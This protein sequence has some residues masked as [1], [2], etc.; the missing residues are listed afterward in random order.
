MKKTRLWIT[1]LALAL[2]AWPLAGSR[3]D[4]RCYP[5]PRFVVLSGGL[6]RDTLTNL[7]WQQQA[8][9]TTVTWANAKTYC[10]SSGSS[11]RLPTVRELSSLVDFGVSSGPAIDQAA[12]PGTPATIFWTSSKYSDT[13]W[14]GYAWYVDFSDGSSYSDMVDVS[15]RVRCVR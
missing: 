10:S 12:F 9:S 14:P 6:V 5:K 15:Y 7:V 3:A 1:I 13:A 8:S 11:F 2:A 4:S